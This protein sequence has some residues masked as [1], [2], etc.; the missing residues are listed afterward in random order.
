M[1]TGKPIPVSF[2]EGAGAMNRGEGLGER[3]KKRQVHCEALGPLAQ[4]GWI[5]W[6]TPPRK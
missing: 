5:S 4:L 6:A 3:F 2:R 1:D